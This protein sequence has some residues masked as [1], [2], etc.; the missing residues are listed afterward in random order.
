MS[1]ILR[2]VRPIDLQA[3]VAANAPA[4][5]KQTARESWRA[6]LSANGGTGQSL[7]DLEMSYLA[8][9]GSSGTTLLDRWANN[10]SAQSGSKIKEKIKNKYK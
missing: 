3:W 10:I 1:L 6:F 2:T 4:S 7:R 5:L 8:G 9:Q